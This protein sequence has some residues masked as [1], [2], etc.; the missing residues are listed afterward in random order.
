MVSLFLEGVHKSR[1]L[2]RQIWGFCAFSKEESICQNSSINSY[3]FTL[4]KIE[5]EDF[6]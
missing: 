1:H 2:V 6:H 5:I 4:K 3:I